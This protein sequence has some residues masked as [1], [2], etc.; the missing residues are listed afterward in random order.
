MNCS[1][2]IGVRECFK[3]GVPKPLNER[4]KPCKSVQNKKDHESRKARNCKL[5]EK[6]DTPRNLP[7][8]LAVRA[9][10]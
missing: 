3:C 6:A 4:C 10:V 2:N 8:T 1:V 5:A 9:W 7:S